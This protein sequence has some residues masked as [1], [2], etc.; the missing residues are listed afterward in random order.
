VGA[1]ALLRKPLEAEGLQD[2]VRDLLGTA[3]AVR[4]PGQG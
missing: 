3:L 4:A 2:R 1:D